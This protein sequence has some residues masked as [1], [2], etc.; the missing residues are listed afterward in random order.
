MQLPGSSE[1]P[2]WGFYSW[3]FQGWNVTS[4]WMITRSLGRSWSSSKI[5]LSKQF[6]WE[7]RGVFWGT[8]MVKFTPETPWKINIL[9]TPKMKV[10]WFKWFSFSN[11][12]G[13]VFKFQ[14]AV[15]FPGW[16]EV[17]LFHPQGVFFRQRNLLSL[18]SFQ[19]A[20]DSV[21]LPIWFTWLV[22]TI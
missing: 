4:I 13:D 19:A 21:T 12:P 2:F 1:W 20:I 15:H 22:Q 7:F 11:F 3:P 5:T 14:K 6:S 9:N 17:F 10:V 8:M 16:R 18:Q